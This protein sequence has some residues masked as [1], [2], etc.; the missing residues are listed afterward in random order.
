MLTVKE[1][2]IKLE[3][4]PATVYNHLKK[5]D[6]EIQSSIIRKKGITYIDDDGIKQLKT[7]MGLI[8]VPTIRESIPPEQIIKDISDLVTNNLKG[9]YHILQSQI[10]EL[11]DQNQETQEQN[12]ILIE[13]INQQ[14]EQKT[15]GQK[16]KGLFNKG[17]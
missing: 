12:K 7:S 5:L 14:M 8:S 17:G 16:I 6:K 2:A 1:I 10:Q 9:D 13:F 4:T 15:L 3:V 11:Q